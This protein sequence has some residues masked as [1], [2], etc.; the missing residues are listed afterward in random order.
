FAATMEFER[1]YQEAIRGGEID[2]EEMQALLHLDAAFRAQY[3]TY[4]Q[5]LAE[6]GSV[7]ATIAAIAVS[8]VVMAVTGGAGAPTVAVLLAQMGASGLW[9]AGSRVGAHRLLRGEHFELDSAE[10]RQEAAAGFV[11]GALAPLTNRLAAGVTGLVGLRGA[12]L[13]QGAGRL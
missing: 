8:V 7:G 12:A 6:I 1:L 2:E 10:A 13:A 9:T 3:A 4:S 11:E 5:D